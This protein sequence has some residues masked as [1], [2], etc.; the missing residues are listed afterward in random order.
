LGRLLPFIS[1]PLEARLGHRQP[2]HSLASNAFVAL[3]TTPLILLIGFQ[4][5]YLIP[6]AFFSHLIL[7]M[8]TLQGPML[9]W[10]LAD[11]RYLLFGGPIK[12]PGDRTERRLAAVLAIACTILLMVVDICPPKPAPV[13]SLSYAQTIERYYALRGRNL[14]FADVEGTWQ[15]T[16]RRM[17]GRF[18]ILNAANESFILLDRYDGKV[19]TAGRSAN[20]NL[21]LNRITLQ[22]GS[23][24]RVKPA[25]IH[26]QDEPL[27]AGLPVLYEMQREPGLQHI[28]ISGD[29]VLPGPS[30]L[31]SPTLPIDYAQ[32][33]SRRIQAQGPGR[34]RLRYL[35]ASEL[36]ALANQQV[37]AAD[38]VIVGTYATAET[39]PT[40]TRLPAPPTT[41][42]PVP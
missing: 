19:F 38:L 32:T 42:E 21:Y 29:V 16:S 23:P 41:P 15:T 14:V 20:D 35:T 26:L 12:S 9:F 31:I 30:N 8:L 33:S 6:L 4:A 2:W 3:I 34:Y 11:T 24:V 5:W 22:P 17:S 37:V 36:I 7:D 10:P 27:A 28:Y 13:P 40:V 18:E 1:R 39:G 25:E